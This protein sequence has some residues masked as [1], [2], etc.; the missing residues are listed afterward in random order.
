L[1]ES[2]FAG[3]ER[4]LESLR[5]HVGGDR[6]SAYEIQLYSKRSATKSGS[7]S[8]GSPRPGVPPPLPA[9]A[10]PSLQGQQQFASTLSKSLERLQELS[11][12][13][14]PDHRALDSAIEALIAAG[15][16]QHVERLLSELI[17][18]PGCHPAVGSWWMRCRISRGRLSC[19]PEIEKQCPA[20]PAACYAIITLIE[21]LGEKKQTWRL[22][23]LVWRHR[24][25]IRQHDLAWGIVGYA[26][27]R[28]QRYSSV[29]RWMRDWKQRKE[30]KM[31][32]LSNL[33]VALRARRLRK[34]TDEVIAHVMTMPD[35]DHAFRSFRLLFAMEEALKGRTASAAEHL[36]ELD[37]NGW[38]NFNIVRY[39]CLEGMVAIQQAPPEKRREV[40]RERRR[41]IG[42]A[43][44]KQGLAWS[45]LV[46]HPDYRRCL[47]RMARDARKWWEF[48]MI[49]LGC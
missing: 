28:A 22:R 1:D 5:R 15:H 4:T 33:E 40:F 7:T 37:E 2:D 24:R 30:L 45:A 17:H 9:A 23:W 41:S 35:R 16:Q 36:R 48:P 26:L 25:W 49:A 13:Q 19:R 11:M 10:N 38:T 12:S 3:A 32:M 43:L 42:R 47:F 27:V 14:D 29:R 34:E 20:N 44:D 8:T 39:R 21:N 46:H 31:W 6:V 18:K